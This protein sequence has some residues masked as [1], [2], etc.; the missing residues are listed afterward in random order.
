MS[1]TRPENTDK[2][3]SLVRSH[4]KLNRTSAVFIPP[5][6]LKPVR[7]LAIGIFTDRLISVSHLS[8][9]THDY[10]K[11]LPTRSPRRGSSPA[12]FKVPERPK[13]RSYEATPLS[14]SPRPPM[15]RRHSSSSP[16]P[17]VRQPKLSTSTSTSPSKATRS[18]Q[19]QDVGKGKRKA[20]PLASEP[21]QSQL[22]A[23]EEIRVLRQE[24]SK[25]RSMNNTS[26]GG[27]FGLGGSTSALQS[28]KPPFLFLSL[29]FLR[30]IDQL[31]AD[32]GGV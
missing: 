6:I 5:H 9:E 20:K 25:A 1:P 13:D 16:P 4:C 28:R 26:Q 18:A 22:L 29:C 17:P 10:L 11:R 3:S 32:R 8:A 30:S 14:S 12:P 19:D 23:R 31:I 7:P 24:L 27:S 15:K 2:S 21:T